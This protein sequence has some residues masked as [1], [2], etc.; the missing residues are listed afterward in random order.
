MPRG[1][2]PTSPSTISRR[3]SARSPTTSTAG[4]R[5]RSSSSASP[6]RTARRRARTGSRNASRPAA[7]RA[8]ILGTLGNGLVGALDA[9]ARTTP[10]AAEVHET[11]AAP[12]RRRRDGRGDGGLVARP[13]AGA[14]QRGRVR[15]RAVHEPDA[16]SSRLSRHDGGVRGGEGRALRVADARGLR[17][18]RRRPVRPHA[19]RHGARPRTAGADLR[20][21]QRRHRG[22]AR[23][24]DAGRAWSSRS[25]TPWGR[26]DIA[27]RLSGTFNASNVLGVLGVLLASGVELDAALAAL[28]RVTPPPGRMQRLG[29]GAAAARRDRLRAHARRARQG[30]RRAAAGRGGGRRARLRVRLRRRA[31]SRQ[32]AGDGAHRGAS[33]PIAS[34]SPTTIRAARIP[35]RSRRRSSTA[36]ARRAGTISRC[37]LDRGAAI[38]A[39]VAGAR[40][41][42]V[43]LVAGKGHEPYQERN[44]VRTPFSDA[45]RRRGARRC[46]R[47][48]SGA[49]DGHGERRAR[50]G[51]PS[52][53]R[54]RALHAR[55][56]RHAHA[57][58]GRSLRGAQGRALRRAR[59]RRRRARAEARSPRSSSPTGPDE[60]AGQ[61]HRRAGSAARA[62]QAGRALA[63]AVR[64]AG[65]RRRRQQRQDD[66]E[67]DAGVGAARSLRRR[68]RA[69]D[70]GQSQQRDRPAAD[71][72]RAARGACRGGDRARHESSRRDGGARRHRA[73][74]DRRRQQRAARAP[75]VHAHVADVAAEHAAIIRALPADGVAVF[76]ADDAHADVWRAAARERRRRARA[77]FRAR[78]R[79]GD[80]SARRGAGR[81]GD[82][83]RHARGRGVRAARGAGTAQR[84]ERARGR[85]GGAGDR[86]AARGDRAR[87]RGV[88]SRRRTAGGAALRRRARP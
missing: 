6:G 59:F 72:A 17:D 70:G 27:P 42:D 78:R 41:G 1:A 76:N 83:A 66:G 33:S 54:E 18:Q 58:A 47:D 3:S 82:R 37:W 51:R 53:G 26:G 32:A 35:P 19:R 13:R 71:A 9:S 68:A 56:H 23:R 44:G 74:D 21:R 88:P 24:G 14:R 5:A 65:D 40:A 63:R 62:G 25:S 49:H 80:A 29:G 55:G 75:G 81:R 7:G 43:V 2:C 85:G 57:R 50:G 38:R 22:D 11:L 79:R 28:A 84:V 86:R 8:A 60:L 34:S 30:A 46:A 69:R 77:R 20:P 48:W 67:G 39:A 64:A 10:D 4:R 73:A 52:H 31:R 15:R 87:A 36:F 16:R 12:A 61:P 45:D